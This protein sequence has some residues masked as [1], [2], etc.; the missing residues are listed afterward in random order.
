MLVPGTGRTGH[1]RR[2]T[3]HQAPGNAPS[4]SRADETGRSHAEGFDEN[5]ETVKIEGRG[6]KKATGISHC[7]GDGLAAGRNRSLRAGAGNYRRLKG[8]E[9][10]YKGSPK[11]GRLF[12]AER[13]LCTWWW[14]GGR[15]EPGSTGPRGRGSETRR[16][17][18]EG[19]HSLT[20]N[21]KVRN[22]HEH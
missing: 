2:L 3:D 14:G 15:G 22:G 20:G 12:W 18:E 5:N 16:G 1:R 17:A 8:L 6:G 10:G 13:F 4:R 11:K 9:R 7:S 19:V 21:E